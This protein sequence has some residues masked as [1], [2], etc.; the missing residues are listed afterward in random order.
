RFDLSPSSDYARLVRQIREQCVG[1]AE[2]EYR[3]F[4]LAKN[5]LKLSRHTGTRQVHDDELGQPGHGDYRLSQAEIVRPGEVED[6]RYVA[7]ALEPLTHGIEPCQSAIF[8]LAQQEDTPLVQNIERIPHL[9][10]VTQ[11]V[12]ELGEFNII[13]HHRDRA[14]LNEIR[15]EL[16]CFLDHQLGLFHIIRCV[17]IPSC[18]AI[19]DRFR[20]LLH[21]EER[22]NEINS[23]Q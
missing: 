8:E 19:D 1:V 10:V 21:V 6:H 7:F 12:N 17:E 22:A 13:H 11:V 2:C 15:I 4:D 14:P 5:G 9:L 20:N 3:L 16:V 18:Y 23:V